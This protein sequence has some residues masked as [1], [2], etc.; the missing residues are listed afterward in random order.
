MMTNHYITMVPNSNGDLL[1][2]VRINEFAQKMSERF[3]DFQELNVPGGCDRSFVFTHESRDEQDVNAMVGEVFRESMQG[4]ENS[5]RR[6][7]L[8]L[9]NDHRWDMGDSYRRAI[10]YARTHLGVEIEAKTPPAPS[11]K[12]KKQQFRKNA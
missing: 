9:E 3:E 7:A 11:K 8:R 4:F 6:S 12:P 1:L 2:E 5:G 10:E